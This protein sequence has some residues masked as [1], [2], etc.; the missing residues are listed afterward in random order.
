MGFLNEHASVKSGS[1]LDLL[2]GL[3]VLTHEKTW[4]DDEMYPW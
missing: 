2:P 3:V 4:Y 1:L